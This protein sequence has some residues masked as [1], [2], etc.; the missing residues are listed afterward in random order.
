MERGD[1]NSESDIRR[2]VRCITISPTATQI[3][4][5]T[6]GGG[7]QIRDLLPG[8]STGSYEWM[9]GTSVSTGAT[10]V[11]S[12]AFSADGQ[13]L[14]FGLLNG[15]VLVWNRLLAVMQFNLIGHTSKIRAPAFS[16]HGKWLASGS[17]DGAIRIWDGLAQGTSPASSR[18]AVSTLDGGTRWVTCV[19]FSPDGIWLVAG[20]ADKTIRVWEVSSWVV[21]MKLND[22]RVFSATFS[23]D[24]SRLVFHGSKGKLEIWDTG[25]WT[26]V[27]PLNEGGHSFSDSIAFSPDGSRLA[28]G[29][30]SG[31]VRIIQPK[32]NTASTSEISGQEC[33]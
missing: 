32:R 4:A 7:I 31:R 13:W 26:Q 23:P 15:S 6:K 11:S 12:M 17:E 25:F 28:I 5:G 27:M 16:S 19:A 29:S 3:A 33:T 10:E 8:I 2:G 30:R 1:W 22:K 18:D 21:L 24:G 14:A 20:S 9:K